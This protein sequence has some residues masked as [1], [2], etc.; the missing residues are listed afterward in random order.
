[1]TILMRAPLIATAALAAVALVHRTVHPTPPHDLTII[2][3]DYAFDAPDS[4]PAGVTTIHFQNQ[5]RDLHHVVIVRLDSGHTV[6]DFTAAT[7]GGRPWPP[8][9]A[10][11]GGPNAGLPG[12]P[13]TSATL[14]LAPGKYWITCLIQSP[15]STTHVMTSHAA[16]GMMHP[17]FVTGRRTS[18]PLPPADVTISLVDYGFGLSRPLVVGRHVIRVKNLSSQPHE[19]FLARLAPGKAAADLLTWIENPA[20]PPPMIPAGGLTPIDAGGEANVVVDLEPGEYGLYCFVNDVR[21][22][23]LHALHGMMRQITVE[24]DRFA[25]HR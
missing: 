24:P 19:M 3:Y 20:G 12:G 13:A 10:W 14:N 21:D 15:D 8:W 4:I 25:Q 1:M 2:A 22:G 6:E 17:L 16:M 23:R 9:I 11:I 18:D 5:G 7:T